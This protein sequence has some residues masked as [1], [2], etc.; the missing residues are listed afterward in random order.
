[1]P[2]KLTKELF[3]E[4]SQD[5]H[6][7]TYDYDSSD[8]I[9]SYTKIKI[10]CKEH[11]EFFQKPNAHLAGKGCPECGK[12]RKTKNQCLPFEKFEE[13][14]N[15]IHNN[16]YSYDRD[17]YT[18]TIDYTIIT[19]PI[20]GKFSQ[21][22]M[23]HLAGYGCFECGKTKGIQ[24]CKTNEEYIGQ[25]TEIHN[26]FYDYSNT[27]YT[28]SSEKIKII[29][30]IHGE[31]EQFATG[32]LSGHGC[33]KCGYLKAVE[34][35]KQGWTRTN[36]VEFCNNTNCPYPEVYIITCT[37][38]YESFVKIGM[39]SKIKQR[40]DFIP[41]TVNI[42]NTI[43]GKPERVYDLE[44]KL[45]RSF[46]SFQYRPSLEFAGHTECFSTEILQDPNFQLFLQK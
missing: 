13:K 25:V 42:L 9:N 46:K 20:H 44:K 36:W 28:K 21:L 14:S 27:F 11:G 26:G 41:Y 17:S 4:K 40:L 3:I 15:V 45:H 12:I 6:G 19:C 7:E 22:A 24:P 37:N 10:V 16:Q 18:K 29:C 1:M 2:Q 30:P 38:E 35:G 23:S 34:T 33:R 43:I 5:I 8:Y 39:T 31:F 32:H